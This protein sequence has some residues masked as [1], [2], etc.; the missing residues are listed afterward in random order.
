MK[1]FFV[2]EEKKFYRIGYRNTQNY[3]RRLGIARNYFF[4]IFGVCDEIKTNP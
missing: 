2:R 1:K 3:D 4:Y